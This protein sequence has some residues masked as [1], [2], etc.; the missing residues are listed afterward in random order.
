MRDCHERDVRRR[1]FGKPGFQFGAAP[2][3]LA[4]PPSPKPYRMRFT[5][6][7]RRIDFLR[8]TAISLAGADLVPGAAA[9]LFVVIVV[10]PFEKGTKPGV[11]RPGD[12]RGISLRGLCIQ[13]TPTGRR[14]DEYR[15]QDM[16]AGAGA[17]AG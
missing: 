5:R 12:C 8:L 15:R 6:G 17:D 3:S 4:L 9:N 1:D 14:Y 13:R 7:C 10:D 11:A 2:S 16:R